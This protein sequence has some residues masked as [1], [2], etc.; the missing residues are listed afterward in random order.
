M[1]KYFW[2]K[3][4]HQL[5]YCYPLNWSKP[6]KMKNKSRSTNTFW[7]YCSVAVEKGPLNKNLYRKNYF[8]GTLSMFYKQLCD[9]TTGWCI[10]KPDGG[11]LSVAYFQK[12]NSYG[13]CLFLNYRLSKLWQFIDI[14]KNLA[15]YYHPFLTKQP[16]LMKEWRNLKRKITC[17]LTHQY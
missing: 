2:Y 8:C 5:L 15:Q 16:W 6:L 9:W 7:F 13:G 1:K 14:Y 17:N 11:C 4:C 10:S 12:K 3:Y